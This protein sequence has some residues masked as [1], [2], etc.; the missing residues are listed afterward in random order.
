MVVAIRNL[1]ISCLGE[2]GV[3]CAIADNVAALSPYHFNVPRTATR[4]PFLLY[5]NGKETKQGGL[6]LVSSCGTCKEMVYD[7]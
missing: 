1:S 5:R 6:L 7:K 4:N 3:V 2:G